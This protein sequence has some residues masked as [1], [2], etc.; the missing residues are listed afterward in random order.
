M[1]RFSNS[2]ARLRP[3]AG[4]P[5]VVAG[6]AAGS[7]RLGFANPN[8]AKRAAGNGWG[9]SKMNASWISIGEI[10]G[11]CQVVDVGQKPVIGLRRHPPGVRTK[12]SDTTRMP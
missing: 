11:E 7:G 8:A 10:L 9:D 1:G 2:L 5:G 3:R 12:K 4:F 6:H